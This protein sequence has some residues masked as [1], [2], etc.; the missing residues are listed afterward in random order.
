MAEPFIPHSSMTSDSRPPPVQQIPSS[1][2]LPSLYVV[3]TPEED[4]KEKQIARENT[5]LV[6]KLLKSRMKHTT[7]EPWRNSSIISHI[8]RSGSI[9]PVLGNE[10][11]EPRGIRHLRKLRGRRSNMPTLSSTAMAESVLQELEGPVLEELAQEE[12]TQPGV[13][14][15]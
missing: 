6:A 5:V 7:G 9:R 1:P 2:E 11:D 12:T 8:E 3:L 15:S 4:A 13:S 10:E 14:S